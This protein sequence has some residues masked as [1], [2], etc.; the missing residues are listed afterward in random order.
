MMCGLG[1]EID[2][3]E[4][5]CHTVGLGDVD[6]ERNA[7]GHHIER[8]HLLG[9]IDVARR[10]GCYFTGIFSEILVHRLGVAHRHHGV[11]ELCGDVD[12]GGF[13]F[14]NSQRG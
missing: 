7:A 12:R 5:A 10:S 1:L 8:A 13:V 9:R 2:G 3:V 11:A 4:F 14:E 6:V